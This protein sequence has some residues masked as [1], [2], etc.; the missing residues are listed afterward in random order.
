VTVFEPEAVE[1]LGNTKI[2]LV[3]AIATS[4]APSLATEINAV[5]S[6][7]VTLTFRDWNPTVNVNTGTAPRRV[8][9]KNQFPREGLAG[10]QGIPVSYPYDPQADDADPNNQAKATL[11]EELELFAVIRK[12]IDAETAFAADDQVEVWKVRCGRQT[13]G[14]SGDDEFAEYE[15]TQMLYP[16]HEEAYGAVVA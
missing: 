3:L 10:Y 16:L 13:R 11:T 1:S 2:K 12:G 4:T 15:I 6:V 7:D 14:R 8:G 5:S 9:T